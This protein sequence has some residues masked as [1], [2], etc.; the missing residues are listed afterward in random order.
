VILAVGADEGL[1]STGRRMVPSGR[2]RGWRVVA[3]GGG[4][5]AGGDEA[6]SSMRW[7]LPA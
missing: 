6:G 1:T 4:V 7:D 3:E 2:V 5:F